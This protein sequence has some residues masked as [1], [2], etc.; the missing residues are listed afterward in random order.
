ML[1]N[2]KLIETKLNKNAR[3]FSAT[4]III[5]ISERSYEKYNITKEKEYTIYNYVITNFFFKL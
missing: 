3:L 4:P 2:I 1:T 5:R